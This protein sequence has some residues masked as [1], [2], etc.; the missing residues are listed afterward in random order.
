MKEPP[1]HERSFRVPDALRNPHLM[2]IFC[3]MELLYKYKP[4]VS[5]I[6]LLTL[7]GVL[8]SLVGLMLCRLSLHWLTVSQ[9]GSTEFLGLAGVLGAFVAYRYC[10]SRIAWKNLRRLCRV[11]EKTCLFA[12]QG[13]RS[14]ILIG[15]MMSL[16]LVF[17]N[18]FVP[19]PYL[20]TLYTTIGGALLLSSFHYYGCLWR[21]VV[22]KGSCLP[23]GKD[24]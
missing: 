2:V 7:A 6:W 23:P 8:W 5:K 3:H 18:S 15:L 10:F 12:F 4:G 16:G 21:L 9:W 13:W 19:K 11:E 14:Y 20:A 24:F 17:R 22:Q 1:G